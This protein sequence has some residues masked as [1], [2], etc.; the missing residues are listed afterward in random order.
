EGI[1]RH[2]FARL[3]DRYPG[4]THAVVVLITNPRIPLGIPLHGSA[5]LFQLCYVAEEGLDSGGVVEGDVGFVTGVRPPDSV[6]NIKD[7]VTV[8]AGN[9]AQKAA[10]IPL[11]RAFSRRIRSSL[12]LR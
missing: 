2:P 6:L 10:V 9:V 5:P 3:I 4:S 12:Q 8:A 11:P 1:E 7:R